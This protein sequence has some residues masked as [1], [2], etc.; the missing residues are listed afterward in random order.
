MDRR[1]DARKKTP[2][3][4]GPCLSMFDE[5]LPRLLKAPLEEAEIDICGLSQN[6]FEWIIEKKME[7]KQK[8]LELS[9]SSGL[10]TFFNE[11][12]SLPL[13][14]QRD[15]LKKFP[16]GRLG[17]FLQTKKKSFSFTPN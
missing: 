15:V 12:F 13:L 1:H 16:A 2:K 9:A 6:N 14:A 8:F 5:V 11:N 17:D 3:P 7:V 10:D 4:G